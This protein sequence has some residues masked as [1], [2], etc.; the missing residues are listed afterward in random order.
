M[1]V[2]LDSMRQVNWL[3]VQL[4]AS[5]SIEWQRGNM[6]G[7]NIA[8]TKLNTM[9]FLLNS[10]DFFQPI[11]VFRLQ[12]KRS[13]NISVSC[14][15]WHILAKLSKDNYYSLGIVSIRVGSHVPSSYKNAMILLTFLSKCLHPLAPRFTSCA[16]RS[17]QEVC[18]FKCQHFIGRIL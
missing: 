9:R 7:Q 3:E 5:E 11:S 12:D 16:A 18:S 14:V 2:S 17:E 10:Y 6:D 1:W 15:S 8:I 13:V 4:A